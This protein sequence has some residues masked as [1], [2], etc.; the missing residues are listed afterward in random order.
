M[1]LNFR[2]YGDGEALII[3]HGLFGSLDNWHSISLK[4][5]EQFQV[6]AVDQRNHGRSPH[7]AEMDYPV[8]AEDLLE[9]MHRQRLT[10]AHVLGHSMGGKTA[11]QFALAHPESVAKLIVADM[12]PRLYSPRHAK[13]LEALLALK[14]EAF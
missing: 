3:L 1:E 9:F 11:M 13:V 14:L 6:F 5:A 8:M 2:R 10:R 7:S 12:A 4:L